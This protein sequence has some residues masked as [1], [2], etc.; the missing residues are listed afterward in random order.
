[1]VVRLVV[2]ERLA[3]IGAHDEH[4]ASV[5]ALL[6]HA[7]DPRDLGVGD[8]HGREVAV[9]GVVRLATEVVRPMGLGDVGIHEERLVSC[10]A[11]ALED[12]P[13][14][15]PRRREQPGSRRRPTPPRS[16]A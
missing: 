13:Y 16:R 9:E 2:T 11:K 8:G 12:R 15:T 4:P 14:E 10:A 7:K 6:E 5:E 1:M 3:M